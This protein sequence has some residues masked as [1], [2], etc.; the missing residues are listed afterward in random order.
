MA[1]LFTAFLNKQMK[2]LFTATTVQWSVFTGDAQSYTHRCK[3]PYLPNW[4]HIFQR[5]LFFGACGKGHYK[6]VH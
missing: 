4:F 3:W 5:E 6:S 2:L 1:V